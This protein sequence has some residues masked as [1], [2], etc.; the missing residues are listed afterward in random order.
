MKTLGTSA[1]EIERLG[2]AAEQLA[3]GARR[4]RSHPGGLRAGDRRHPQRRH[5]HPVAPRLVAGLD[6][7][8]QPRRSRAGRRA[9]QPA[10]LPHAGRRASSCRRC[11]V[12]WSSIERVDRV[13]A[14]D[15]CALGRWRRRP[16]PDG[17]LAVE[18]RARQLRVRAGVPVLDRHHVRGRARRS[19]GH[20]GLD[21]R[22][23]RQPCASC[24]TR[25]ADP[26]DRCRPDRRRRHS[27]RSIPTLL[28]PSVALVFQET[29]LFAES[30]AREH[31][32]RRRR[33]RP[34]R[35]V[36]RRGIARADRFVLALPAAAT[37]RS[38][39]SAGSR[40]R[41]DSASASRWPGR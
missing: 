35:S 10:R 38:S 25:L 32:A 23:A 40:S 26:D 5:H 29:F 19:G 27:T 8:A 13:L 15:S 30:I 41:A 2:E 36:R 14:T 11:R 17:P 3:S 1:Q 28:R 9:V 7:A 33:T 18:F 21:G 31:H 24:I 6:R 20:R 4:C 22:R 16:L 12:R 37:T 34:T 39:A